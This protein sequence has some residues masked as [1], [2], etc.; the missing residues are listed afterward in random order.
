V[1]DIRITTG[2]EAGTYLKAPR[3]GELDQAA[4]VAGNFA[5]GVIRTF[6]ALGVV[7]S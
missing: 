6:D 3:F 1:T 4:Y 7:F 5:M 2:I